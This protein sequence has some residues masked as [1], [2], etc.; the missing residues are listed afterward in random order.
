MNTKSRAYLVGGG[1]GSLAVALIIYD[2]N[3]SG[4][5]TTRQIAPCPVGGVIKVFT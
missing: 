3:L 5:N 1:I 4:G 2:G